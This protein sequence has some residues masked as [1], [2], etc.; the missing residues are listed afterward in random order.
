MNNTHTDEF[1]YFPLSLH[2]NSSICRDNVW[3]LATLKALKET[4]SHLKCFRM[5]HPTKIRIC[6][7]GCIST[8]QL[9]PSAHSWGCYSSKLWICVRVLKKED[10]F[11][12]LF[13]ATKSSLF[14]SGE[15]EKTYTEESLT[16]MEQRKQAR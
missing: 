12:G 10:S 1:P 16:R 11:C 9:L 3:L 2:C 13:Y 8:L 15:A 6:G 7:P 5:G 14:V 4:R